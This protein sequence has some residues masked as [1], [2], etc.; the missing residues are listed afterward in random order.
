M[1]ARDPRF[2]RTLGQGLVLDTFW[3]MERR[4][5]DKIVQFLRDRY[6]F[7]SADAA[8]ATVLDALFTDPL[9]RDGE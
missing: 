1:L 9:A 3:L 7:A 8:K 4:V 6:D 2:H 5:P